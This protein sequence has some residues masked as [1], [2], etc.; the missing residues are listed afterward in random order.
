MNLRRKKILAA[1][2]LGVGKNKIKF[3]SDSLNEIKEAIT[4]LDIK[5]L[6][7][8]NA[9]TIK[10]KKGR[11]KITK[12]KTKVRQGKIK[13]NVNTRKRDYVNLTRKLRT[14]AKS[15]KKQGKVTRDE[16][17]DIRKK[18]KSKLYKSKA[19]LKENLK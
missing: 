18:I 5:D 7:N 13:K 3:D 4:S 1:K 9:I 14:F 10:E 19:H 12:R 16:Y 8:S 11:K 2:K 17:I 6:K 15:L